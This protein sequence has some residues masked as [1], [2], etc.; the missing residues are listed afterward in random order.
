MTLQCGFSSLSTAG[1]ALLTI[2]SCFAAYVGSI[3]CSSFAM[4]SLHGQHHLMSRWS[5]PEKPTGL[6]THDGMRVAANFS[7]IHSTAAKLVPFH[8]CKYICVALSWSTMVRHEGFCW[9]KPERLAA[10]H[11]LLHDCI[12][13]ALLVALKWRMVM[14]AYNSIAV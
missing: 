12:L 6:T 8:Q 13:T 1:A 14:I 4:W 5:A 9:Q 10:L 11:R 3:I 2:S 7:S